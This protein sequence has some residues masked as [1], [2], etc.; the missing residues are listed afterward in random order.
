MSDD[1]LSDDELG[2][3]LDQ[4]EEE[5]DSMQ[6]ERQIHDYDFARP[7]KLNPEQIRALQR[8]YESVAQELE[9][10]LTRLLRM[11]V[12]I[13]L[14]SLGQLSYE[15]FRN[16]LYSP[17]VIHVLEMTPGTERAIMTADTKLSL[18]LIDRML[19]GDGKAIEDSVRP[20]TGVEQGLL[21]NITDRF[22]QCLCAG[23]RR[24]FSFSM[25][26]VERESDP[27]FVQV[28]PAQEMVLVATFGVQATGSLE[29]GE[30]CICIPFLNIEEFIGKI[31]AQN[32]F[33]QVR[34]QQT[35]VQKNY[36]ERV[37]KE[38]LVPI[39]VSLGE[40]TLDLGKVMSLQVGDVVVLDQRKDEPLK[41]DVADLAKLRGTAGNCG[42]KYGLLLSEV[43]PEGLSP[44]PQQES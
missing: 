38:T 21:D 15:V 4:I 3:L 8:M 34:R 13:D 19:G 7:D 9:N 29:P 32:R 12:E 25:K 6:R 41:A 35:E 33:A 39:E 23:W 36:L 2:A 17:T 11:S 20:L 1:I 43:S 28:I 16:S 40:A 18:S 42:R 22:Q 30:V 24:F 26:V 37:I 27:Q 31:G 44:R 14:I 5:G 10:T